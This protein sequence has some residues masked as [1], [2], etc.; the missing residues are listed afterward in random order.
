MPSN[1]LAAIGSF[2]RRLWVDPRYLADLR[3]HVE[4]IN[5]VLPVIEFDMDGRVLGANENFQKAAGYTAEELR[6]LHHRDFVEADYRETAEYRE[7]WARLRRGE[8]QTAQ[9]K[10]IKKNGQPVWVQATYF[11]ILDRRG[12]P[13]KVVKHTVDITEQ[14]LRH[15]DGLGQLAAISKVQAVV[16]LELDGTIR[17]ANDNFLSLV[18]YSIDEIRGRPFGI[19]LDPAQQADAENRALWARLA[20]GEYEAGQYE[21]LAKGNRKLWVRASFN[22][23]LDATGKPFKVVGYA[24][25]VTA[26]VT[27]VR[28]TEAVVNAA[29]S[30]DL[31]RRISIDGKTGKLAEVARGVNALIEVMASLVERIKSAAEEVR[32]GVEQISSGNMSLSQRTDEQASTLEETAASMEELASSV[33]QIADNAAQANRLAIEACTQAEK[34][35]TVVGSAIEAMEGINAASARIA[36]IIGVVDS[37][38]F[39]TNLLALNAAVEAA[40]AGE[41]GRGFAVVASEVRNLASRSAMAAKEIKSLIQ[42]S[43]QRVAEGGRL[44]NESGR[45]LEEIV[46]AVRR[47]TAI[48]AEI[49]AASREQSAGIEQVNHAVMQMENM[50]QQNAALVEEAAASTDAIVQQVRS[51]NDLVAHYRLGTAGTRMR[52]AGTEALRIQAS[53][54]EPVA[55][56]AVA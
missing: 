53:T 8:C 12:R 11:P 52:P 16:E 18:G 26:E 25:D 17:A 28:E 37:I 31:T 1:P 3:G 56:H 39:Q 33:R 35:G 15:F 34:G 40:R 5:R 13:Y 42:D 51:L 10:R 9:Y 23:I 20:R 43:V 22:P 49:A 24:T 45:T 41:Q 47:A 50:T 36:D 55:H 29:A 54:S 38:A 30:G 2:F 32:A 44:V 46:T 4:A 14:M 6:R 7:F 48:V 19:F 21:W 27:L